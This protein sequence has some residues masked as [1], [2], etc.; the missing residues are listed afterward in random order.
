[1]GVAQNLD[2]GRIHFAPAD[3]KTKGLP[4]GLPGGKARAGSLR[5][6]SPAGLKKWKKA[7]ICRLFSEAKKNKL[8]SS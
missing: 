2:A 4:P 7:A 3:E 8:K 5:G 6:L 1:M